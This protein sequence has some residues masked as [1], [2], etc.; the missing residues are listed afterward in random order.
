MQI[1]S[2]KKKFNTKPS[3]AIIWYPKTQLDHQRKKGKKHRANIEL[4]S[5]SPFLILRIALILQ[6][7]S[8]W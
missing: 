6:L 2:K 7:G 1:S 8:K 3:K 5:C 4:F